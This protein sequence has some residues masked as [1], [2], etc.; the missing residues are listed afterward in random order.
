MHYEKKSTGKQGNNFG[1]QR[2]FMIDMVKESRKTLK[3][4]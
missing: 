1:T 4:G 2:L 3:S